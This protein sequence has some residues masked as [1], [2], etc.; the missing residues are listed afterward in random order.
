VLRTAFVLADGAAQGAMEAGM[1]RALYE[2]NI[3]PDLLGRHLRRGR[4][5]RVPGLPPASERPS[6]GISSRR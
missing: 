4:Q 3:V 6:A 5:C 1:V 2:R